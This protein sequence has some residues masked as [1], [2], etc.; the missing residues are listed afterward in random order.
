MYI[1]CQTHWR[2]D[3]AKDCVVPFSL[4]EQHSCSSE[5]IP[6]QPPIQTAPTAQSTPYSQSRSQPIPSY[7]NSAPKPQPIAKTP[8]SLPNPLTS[9]FDSAS[10]GGKPTLQRQPAGPSLTPATHPDA[11]GNKRKSSPV[12]IGNP[13]EK[14]QRTEQEDDRMAEDGDD[15]FEDDGPEQS[16]SAGTHVFSSPSVPAHIE[17]D[18]LVAVKSAKKT[19]AKRPRP[20]P[21][22]MKTDPRA[23][24]LLPGHTSEV[25]TTC[26][27]PV[28]PPNILCARFLSARGIR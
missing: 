19:K 6:L 14:R 23:I 16:L 20:G 18:S 24:R 13:N 28:A 22:D 21:G 1:E 2:S 27:S 4:L 5:A 8:T 15:H 12:D 7:S 25:C 17:S 11:A 9:Q 26:F 3:T 10:S